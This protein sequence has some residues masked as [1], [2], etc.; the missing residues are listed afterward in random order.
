[1]LPLSAPQAQAARPPPFP[2]NIALYY[3]CFSASPDFNALG[4]SMKVTARIAPFAI[5]SLAAAFLVTSALAQAQY[6]GFPKSGTSPI[7]QHYREEGKDNVELQKVP[8][9]KMFDNVWYV[10][11]GYVSCYLIKTSAGAILIDASEETAMTDHVI[12]SI[13][14][15]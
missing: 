12:D 1:M 11:P 2:A 9:F 8:P 6:R 7:S 10:G 5:G 3:R 4:G 15:T 13:K 14:K